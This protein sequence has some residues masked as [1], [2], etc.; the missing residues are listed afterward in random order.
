MTSELR[1]TTPECNVVSLVFKG[2]AW[3][4]GFMQDLETNLGAM[5][6]GIFVNAPSQ[7]QSSVKLQIMFDTFTVSETS[8]QYLMFLEDC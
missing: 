6:W 4:I 1:L 7:K 5:Y 3:E 8:K 2:W